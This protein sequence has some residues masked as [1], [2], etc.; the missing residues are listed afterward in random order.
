MARR[1]TRVILDITKARSGRT[2]GAI[3]VPGKFARTGLQTYWNADGSERIEYRPEDEVRRSVD[4]FKGATIT[5]GHPSQGLVDGDTYKADVVG[6]LE[7]PRYEDGWVAGDFVIIHEPT[8]QLVKDRQRPELSAGYIAGY[9]ETPGTYQGKRYDGAQFGIEGN[10]VALLAEGRARAGREA[11]LTLDSDGDLIPPGLSAR[12]QERDSNMKIQV[13]VDGTSIEV[14]CDDVSGQLLKRRLQKAD[15][16]EAELPRVTAERDDMKEKLS[17]AEAKVDSSTT[18]AAIDALVAERS[19]V[20]ADAKAIGYDATKAVVTDANGAT[21][22]LTN[23]EIKR[24]AVKAGGRKLNLDGQDANYVNAYVAAAFDMMVADRK[25][26]RKDGTTILDAAETVAGGHVI[27][28]RAKD[29]V[30]DDAEVEKILDE[31]GVYDALD[32]RYER[33]EVAS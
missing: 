26:Q 10:H 24:E 12:R 28:R 8:K 20:I 25:Q 30:L 19:Q 6:H 15:E 3:V 32:N 5:D 17:A 1:Y 21:R 33:Q 27:Q 9:D 16:L 14:D 2:D 13:V 22:P 4:S 18:P 29:G 7:N 31:E 23:A 11:R